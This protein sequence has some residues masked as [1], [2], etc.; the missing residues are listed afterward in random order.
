MPK[1][2]SLLAYAISR[3]VLA[4]P[5]LLILLTVVFAVL[6]ILPGDPISALYGG[7]APPEVVAAARDRLGLNKPYWEQY[8][9]YLRQ[10]F[11]GDFG[12]SLGEIYSGNS[13]WATVMLKLPATIEL[14]LGGML[15]ATVVGVGLGVVGGVKRD[16]PVDVAVRLYGTIIWVIPIFWLGLMFQL[17]FSVTLHWLPASLRFDPGVTFPPRV[18]G[19]FTIDSLLEG[20]VDHFVIALSHLVLPSLTLGLV[21]SGFFTKTVRANLLRTISSDYV[22]AAKARGVRPLSIVYRYAFKNALIPVVTILGLQFAI[23][24]AGAVLTE[25]TFSWD[26]MGTLLLDSI[27]SKDYTMIQGTIVIYAVI[28]IV[29]SV[30]ID[31]INGLIDPRVRY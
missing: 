15:V 20:R 13:V 9:I 5:M 30:I 8:W 17:V 19:F 7:R 22:E 11:T 6:R 3:L 1:R 4:L 16:T 12:T 2:A 21:L 10:I 25:R 23:L 27:N 24:F 31:I 28:I 29:I 26:G 14:A 18:T